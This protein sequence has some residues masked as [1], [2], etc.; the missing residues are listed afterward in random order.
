MSCT[1]FD[2]QRSKL[3]IAKLNFAK[4]GKTYNYLV[5]FTNLQNI[6]CENCSLEKKKQIL[7]INANIGFS[8]TNFPQ[9]ACVD[10]F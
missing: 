1:P 10:D 3:T 6:S 5:F 8:S 7:D 2:V 9:I 4:V